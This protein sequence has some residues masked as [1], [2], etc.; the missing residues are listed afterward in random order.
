LQS[1][2]GSFILRPVFPTTLPAPSLPVFAPTLAR[3]QT[4]L[5]RLT[6]HALLVAKTAARRCAELID[7][8]VPAPPRQDPQVRYLK[9]AASAARAIHWAI[10]LSGVL[11]GTIRITAPIP[12]PAKPKPTGIK[13]Q[14]DAQAQPR[15]QPRAQPGAAPEPS[16]PSGPAPAPKPNLRWMR[17]VFATRSI[18]YIATH[19]CRDLGLYYEDEALW[20]DELIAITQTPA[21]YA[22]TFTPLAPLAPPTLQPQPPQ[23]Q[24]AQAQPAQPQPPHPT[25]AT[26]LT[27]DSAEAPAQAPASPDSTLTQAEP[28]PDQNN[29]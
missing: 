21:D 29:T 6:D 3:L 9:A 23:P 26:S 19:I 2:A 8:P 20:P 1:T 24:P 14:P 10:E 25:P 13:A 7:A 5:V 22:A 28:P 12:R 16:E 18:G 17:H 27:P 15:A 4:L 11:A